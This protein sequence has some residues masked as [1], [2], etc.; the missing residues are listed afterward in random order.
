VNFPMEAG[1]T[2]ADFERIYEAAA[3]ILRRF[4]PE[5]V[6]LSAGF[7]AHTDDPL[8]GMRVTTLQFARL[9][10][11]IAGIADE[12]CDGRLVAVTEGGYDLAALAASLRAAID[13]LDTSKPTQTPAPAG[14]TR[15]ADAALAAL[16]PHLAKFWTI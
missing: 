6:L 3:G 8:G 9:T 12:C 11:L 2:D 7:D 1:A 15:R 5:L 16:R 13:V 10:A 4:R 14:D